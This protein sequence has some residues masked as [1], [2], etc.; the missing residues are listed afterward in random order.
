MSQALDLN[1]LPDTYEMPKA[2][3][4]IAAIMGAAL[5]IIVASSVLA[6]DRQSTPM[7]PLSLGFAVLFTG[8]VFAIFFRSSLT[9]DRD[10]FTHQW[11][12]GG[13]RYAW[14]DVSELAPRYAGRSRM[15]VFNDQTKADSPLGGIG[16]FARGGYNSS[17]TA[18]FIGGSLENA[19]ATMNAFRARALRRAA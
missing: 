1:H 19:C 12:L 5:A 2:T 4:R 8:I 9:L 17:I 13:K 10:G 15:I 16:K 11:L 14:R 7:M 18:A 3:W 6:A